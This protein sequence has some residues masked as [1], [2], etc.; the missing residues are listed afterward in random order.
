MIALPSDDS[1]LTTSNPTPTNPQDDTQDGEEVATVDSRITPAEEGT[2]QPEASTVSH[3]VFDENLNTSRGFTPE[4]LDSPTGSGMLP[5]PSKEEGLTSPTA[6]GTEPEGT[7][8]APGSG[9]EHETT[10]PEKD[11]D[12]TQGGK[13][14]ITDL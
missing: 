5:Y 11:E 12:R 13:K 9:E 3:S 1:S 2:V 7:H 14:T 8:P 10:E 6:S 4:D